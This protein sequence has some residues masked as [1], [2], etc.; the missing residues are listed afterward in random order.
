[1]TIMKIVLM[2][3]AGGDTVAVGLL[4]RIDVAKGESAIGWVVEVCGRRVAGET[5][6]DDGSKLTGSEGVSTRFLS[7]V[8][9]TVSVVPLVVTGWQPIKR[10]INKKIPA[11]LAICRNRLANNVCD[12]FSLIFPPFLLTDQALYPR[13]I[14]S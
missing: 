2:F 10:K 14:R 12:L 13:G 9:T 4:T 6:V 3:T 11:D 8:D 1:M 7:V 5:G